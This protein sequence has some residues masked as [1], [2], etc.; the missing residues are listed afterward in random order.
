ME[1]SGTIITER[2]IGLVMLRSCQMNDSLVDRRIFDQTATTEINDL[3]VALKSQQ[4]AS[5]FFDKF[6]VKETNAIS[7]LVNVAGY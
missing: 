4:I 3:L 2:A 7:Q 5:S 1:T 6:V